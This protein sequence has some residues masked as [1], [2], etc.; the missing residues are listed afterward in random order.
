LT[1]SRQISRPAST[2]RPA[3]AVAPVRLRLNPMVTGD[4]ADAS[5]PSAR[6]AAAIN[7]QTEFRLVLSNMI[8]SRAAR[9]LSGSRRNASAPC[10]RRQSF[11]VAC[12]RRHL[13]G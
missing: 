6:H 4:W 2:C 9:L 5:P 3:G 10:V 12:R 1:S 7:A 8:P 11:A 13:I